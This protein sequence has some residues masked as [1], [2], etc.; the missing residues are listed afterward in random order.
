MIKS[1]V[2]KTEGNH[3]VGKMTELRITITRNNFVFHHEEI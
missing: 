1:F 2:Q 3:G